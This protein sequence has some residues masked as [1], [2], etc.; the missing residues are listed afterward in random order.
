MKIN[1]KAAFIPK[2]KK[3]LSAIITGMSRYIGIG[4]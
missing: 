2:L 4:R 3:K 1:E